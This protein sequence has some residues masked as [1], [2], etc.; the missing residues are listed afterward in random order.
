MLVNGILVVKDSKVLKDVNP[1]QPIRFPVE[2]ERRFEPLSLESWQ[3]E[4]LVAP[5]DFG[6][7]DEEAL[8]R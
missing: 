5:T 7:L 2:A 6:A 1:G 4:F 8:Q 3:N